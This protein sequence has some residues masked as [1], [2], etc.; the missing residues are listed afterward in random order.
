VDAGE[1]P[2]EDEAEPEVAGREGGVLGARSLPVV[3][4]PDDGVPGGSPGLSGAVVI[5]RI[6]GVETKAADFGNIAPD[7]ED[8]LQNRVVSGWILLLLGIVP[9]RASEPPEKWRELER[10]R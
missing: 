6:E 1:A 2:G 10:I 5:A 9:D 7:R 3:V 8:A 4:P